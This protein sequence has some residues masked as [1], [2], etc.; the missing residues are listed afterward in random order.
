MAATKPRIMSAPIG[1]RTVLA[2]ACLAPVIVGCTSVADPEGRTVTGTLNSQATGQDHPW[3]I[4][5]PP[6][7]DAGSLLPVI[8][9]LHGIDATVAD[10][11]SLGYTTQAI[12][13]INK[14]AAPFAL[15]AINGGQLFWQ[16]I[17]KADAGKM[18]VSEFLPLLAQHGIDLNRMA[19]T[20][21]SMG[22][23]GTLR[24]ASAE[25]R[26]K[27]KAIAAISSPS[28]QKYDWVPQKQ[29]MTR[30]EFNANNFFVRPTRLANLP[31]FLACGAQDPF[32]PGNRDFATILDSTPSVEPPTTSFGPGVHDA[33]YWQS[34]L[35][36]Q[37]AFLAKHLSG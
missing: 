20:G 27:L 32:Y 26:G 2:A 30:A 19:L 1:R 25:L 35:P 3:A 7:T 18:L 4:W 22:G 36:A 16:K 23:W 21:W 28:Y 34:V 33:T 6:G 12:D 5:Y 37:L 24:L 13:L 31:I 14:G 11:Q 29:W 9:V 10:V 17:G 15:A 8:V